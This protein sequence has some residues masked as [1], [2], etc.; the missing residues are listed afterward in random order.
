M[1]VSR[2]R[3]R[4]SKRLFFFG[5]GA[6]EEGCDED[7]RQNDAADDGDFHAA[8]AAFSLDDLRVVVRRVG[9]FR[10]ERGNGIGMI[11]DM[12]GEHVFRL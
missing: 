11:G 10:L 3:R 9:R 5:G 8:D 1:T 6:E 4:R 7:A 12:E 2:N